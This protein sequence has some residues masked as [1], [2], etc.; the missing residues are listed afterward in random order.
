[1]ITL[2]VIWIL[3]AVT[4]LALGALALF[5]VQAPRS[6]AALKVGDP[7]PDFTLPGHDRRPV[8]LADFRGHNSVILAFYVKASTPG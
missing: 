1:M 8:R 7:A 3:A 5:L 4:V 2:R 6:Q